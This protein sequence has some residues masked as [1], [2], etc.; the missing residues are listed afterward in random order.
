MPL[1]WH[2]DQELSPPLSHC[3]RATSEREWGGPS[4]P[5]QAGSGVPWAAG[6]PAWPGRAR[7][8]LVPAGSRW[9]TASVV[10]G[11]GWAWAVGPQAGGA[12]GGGFGICQSALAV[13][14]I[15]PNLMTI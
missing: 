15:T 1:L 13:G 8:P 7:C 5:R 9:V 14:Q 4:G 11:T 10:S 12:G 3:C 2:G 6:V